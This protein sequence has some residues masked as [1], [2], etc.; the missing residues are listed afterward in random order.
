[1]R[2]PGACDFVLRRQT[3]HGLWSGSVS[4]GQPHRSLEDFVLPFSPD[5]VTSLFSA[6]KTGVRVEATA[7]TAFC[8]DVLPIGSRAQCTLTFVRRPRLT[9]FCVSPVARTAHSVWSGP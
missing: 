8:P 4:L 3:G 2:R 9:E 1:M 6:P 5:R 7:L